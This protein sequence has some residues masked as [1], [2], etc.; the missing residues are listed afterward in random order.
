MKSYQRNLIIFGL[1]FLLAYT[2]FRFTYAWYTTPSACQKCHEIE[3]YY[4]SWQKSAH[5]NTDCRDCHETRGAF[6]RLDSII[7]GI[8]DVSIKIKGDYGLFTNPIYHDSNCITCHIG[9]D[10]PESKAPFMPESHAKIIKNGVGCNNCHRD[11]GHKNGLGV[12][13]KFEILSP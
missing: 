11:T 12:D 3:P 9:N 13:A 2:V 1:I 4:I 7:R 6:H 10:K 8:R 5:K